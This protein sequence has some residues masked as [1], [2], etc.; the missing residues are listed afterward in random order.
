MRKDDLERLDQLWKL[1]V[2]LAGVS[3]TASI[4]VIVVAILWTL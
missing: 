1:A 2:V 3:I 4:V